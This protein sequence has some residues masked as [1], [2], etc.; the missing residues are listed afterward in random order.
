MA[1]ARDVILVKSRAWCFTLFGY[2][3][4]DLKVLAHLSQGS[5]RCRYQEEVCPDTNR[6]HIQGVI[7]FKSQVHF[8][9]LKKKFKRDDVHLEAARDIARSGEYCSKDETRP[10][11][12]KQWS[13]GVWPRVVTDPLLG[14]ERREFQ[15]AIEK[16]LF[17]DNPASDTPGGGGGS[18]AAAA[19]VRTSRYVCGS[20]WLEADERKISWW[21]DYEGALGKTTLAKSLMIRHPKRVAYI[22][23]GKSGDITFTIAG[24]VADKSNDLRLVLFDFPRCLEGHVSYHAIEQIKNGMVFSPKYES[25][26][27]VFCQPHIVVMANWEPDRDK[28]SADRWDVH[29]L[30]SL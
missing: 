25:R 17:L 15:T 7:E 5:K 1:Q 26:T 19:G 9:A 21:V 22:T 14:K 18:S 30:R 2:D 10:P 23:G 4:A 27:V 29:H 13:S 6:E 24:F 16:T 20:D 28:M 12:G 11:G 8:T 3:K